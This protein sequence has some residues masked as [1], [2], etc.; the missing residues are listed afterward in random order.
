VYD[1]VSATVNYQFA[2]GSATTGLLPDFMVQSGSNFV[3]VTGKYL[4]STHD[5]DFSYNA[6]RT[7]W[8]LAMSYIVDGRTDLLASQQAT[9]SWIRAA[10]GG[11]PTKIRA[12]YYVRNGTNGNA[13]ATWDDLAFTAPMAVNAMLGGASSQ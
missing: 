6:C 3:P 13:F 12:G 9:A 1:R 5:G 10:T 2:N 4:E 8:R 7:P 11:V